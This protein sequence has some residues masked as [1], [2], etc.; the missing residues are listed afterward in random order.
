M[1][2][3][4]LTP[5][6]GNPSTH[7]LGTNPGSFAK[8]PDVGGP[9]AFSSPD[10]PGI[11][12]PSD[13]TPWDFMPPDWK[14]EEGRW[15]PAPGFTPITQL[16]HARVGNITPEMTRVAE[17][18]PHLTAEQVR[19]EVAAGRM[20]IPANRVHLAG[21]LDPM[22]IGRASV[23]KVNANMGA[24][25]VSSSIGEEVEKLEWAKRWGSDTVMDLSTGGDLDS[26]REAII[27]NSTLPV[28]SVPIYSMILGRTIEELDEQTVLESLEKQAK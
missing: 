16:E 28:G 24:S 8:P 21:R 22:A 27:K 10:T 20:V 12:E 6:G 11:P 23:T 18:E 2:R 14:L 4:D 19:N 25:P 13:K 3:P 7:S 5:R 9:H 26:T 17:R 15:T 1:E